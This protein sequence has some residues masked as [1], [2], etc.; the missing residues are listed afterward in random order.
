MKNLL[1]SLRNAVVLMIVVLTC[2]TTLA[3]V[4]YRYHVTPHQ[5]TTVV[6]NKHTMRNRPNVVTARHM[7]KKHPGA[8]LTTVIVTQKKKVLNR[9]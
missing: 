7:E 8:R 4:R 2:S 9:Y 1:K 6:I 3:E 5:R